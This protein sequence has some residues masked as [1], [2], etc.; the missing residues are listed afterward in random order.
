MHIM[1]G[2]IFISPDIG[3]YYKINAERSVRDDLH[4]Y[5]QIV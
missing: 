3:T 1:I 4:I 5:Y 2:A